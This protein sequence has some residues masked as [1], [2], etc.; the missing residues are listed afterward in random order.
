M[1]G[2][3]TAAYNSK[4][5]YGVA[6]RDFDKLSDKLSKTE[7]ENAL[8]VAEKQELAE[9]NLILERR[10]ELFKKLTGIERV[11]EL[12]EE[13]FE[14][15]SAPGVYYGIRRIDR[16]G[17]EAL[18]DGY[19]YGLKSHVEDLP[20][21]LSVRGTLGV[22]ML[23]ESL[24]LILP[25]QLRC[26][27]LTQVV[28]LLQ[29]KPYP[30]LAEAVGLTQLNPTFMFG[31]WTVK[32]NSGTNLSEAFF[33]PTTI[34][35]KTNKVLVVIGKA[36]VEMAGFNVPAYAHRNSAYQELGEGKFIETETS[37]ILP[38]KITDTIARIREDAYID[39]LGMAKVR[40]VDWQQ[41]PLFD[42]CIR[43]WGQ[44]YPH[45]ELLEEA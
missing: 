12:D 8:L 20:D 4:D 6:R 32:K 24:S 18:C 22:I 9:E 27:H 36:Q 19:F 41:T 25:K 11:E 33:R 26:D 14:L 7:E 44:H 23:P 43:R 17:L 2:K 30:E 37:Y 13:D 31:K 28:E 29:P 42:D 3:K 34:S 39:G 10:L 1:F 5:D 15:T 16:R 21:A 40:S 45:I 38:I 35:P